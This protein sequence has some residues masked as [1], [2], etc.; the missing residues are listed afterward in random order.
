MKKVT[1]N[2]PKVLVFDIETSPILAYVWKIWDENIG[3]N[4][5]HKDWHILSWSAKWLGD[6]KVMYDDQRNEKNIDNDKRLLE[7]IWKLLDEADIVITQNGKSFDVKKLNARFI[8]NGMQPPSNF[9]H[10]D[11]LRIARKN[12]A[13]TSN[14]LEYMTDKLCTKYK[15]LTHGKFSGFNLWKQCLLGN[16]KAWKEMEKYNK[17]DVLSLEELYT[18]LI[19]WDSTIDFNLYHNKLTN[20][21]KCGNTDLTKKGFIFTAVGKYQAY[22]CKKCG[23]RFRDRT[24]L[25]SKDKRESLKINT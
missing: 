16:M 5:I 13:F 3:L 22:K 24:N 7:K 12:F 14:K 20:T 9:K 21:C 10:I 4:Q 25:F 23:S 2:G 15:K 11:T 8:M 19:P 17:Y 1:N 6:K 18:K